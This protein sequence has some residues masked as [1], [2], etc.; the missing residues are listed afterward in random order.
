MI[1]KQNKLIFI[2][3]YVLDFAW[4]AGGFDVVGDNSIGRIIET[5]SVSVSV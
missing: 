5:V 3:K 2:F 4:I 1:F